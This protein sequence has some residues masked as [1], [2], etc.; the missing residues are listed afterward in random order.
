MTTTTSGWDHGTPI[1]PSVATWHDLADCCTSRAAPGTH[2]APCAAACTQPHANGRKEAGEAA[3]QRYLHA[4]PTALGACRTPV[5]PSHARTPAMPTSTRLVRPAVAAIAAESPLCGRQTRRAAALQRR[6]DLRMWIA[7][8]SEGLATRGQQRGTARGKQRA[9]ARTNSRSCDHTSIQVR[10]YT[11]DAHLARAAAEGGGDAA[12]GCNGGKCPCRGGGRRTD[13]VDR[14][15]GGNGGTCVR[16]EGTRG[17]QVKRWA[18]VHGSKSAPLEVANVVVVPAGNQKSRQMGRPGR[19]AH[20]EAPRSTYIAPVQLW[21]A[22]LEPSQA[23]SACQVV[24][25]CSGGQH[26]GWGGRS[27]S[28]GQS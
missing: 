10:F 4:V 22:V 28:W 6:H 1:V 18:M 25:C 15:R 23:P 2:R 8:V 13:A 17:G 19:A 20:P 14:S 16:V 26:G 9:A 21:A 11:H 7:D 3:E 5:A 12:A 24:R 27:A